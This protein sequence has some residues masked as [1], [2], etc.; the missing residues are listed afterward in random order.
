VSSKL[1]QPRSRSDETA[2]VLRQPLPPLGVILRAHGARSSLSELRLEKGTCIIGAGVDADLIVEDKAVSRRHVELTVVP[3]GVAVRDL[4]SR[5]GTFYLGQRIDRMVLA[6]GSRIT[7][8]AVEV[9]IDADTE[10]LS[11]SGA[12]LETSYRGLLGQSATMRE[13]F[14][15]LARL[16]GSLINCLIE[17]ESGVGKELIAHAL[18]DGSA[19][20]AG[21]F[22][23]VNC[24]AIGKEL[25]L[26]E[27][28]GHKK[29]SFTGATD[30]RTGAF[31]AANGGTLFLDEIGELPLGVQPVLLRALESGEIKPV[32]S[33]VARH[34][35][36]RVVA[37]T[38]RDLHAEA[39]EG[40]FRQDLYYRLAVVKVTVPPLRE[41]LED[42]PLLAAAFARQAGGAELP[43]AIIDRLSARSWPGNAREL[44]NAVLAYLAIG[45]LP[46]GDAP[47]GG[48]LETTLRQVVDPEKPYQDQKE[49]FVSLFGRIYF[50]A[51]LNKT[52][53]NQSEAA[54]LCGVERSYLSK[55]LS[56]FGVKR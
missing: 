9:A 4:D 52:N 2:A 40:R 1:T 14:A 42:V 12:Q 11:A 37:A 39:A 55:L 25:V 41:R 8:G 36:V 48:L 27:L 45:S 24:G 19:L 15:I 50:E 32:G 43:Q 54:R 29:G 28:F 26:S 5:N 16:E 51:L 7:L 30:A 17:G 23:V 33:D 46:D 20:A 3:E 22:V 49:L 13:L 47:V 35:K 18:H 56:K 6:P 21:P 53:G 38:N 34:V 10:Q 31:E 44:R